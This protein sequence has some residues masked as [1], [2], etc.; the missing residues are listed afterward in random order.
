MPEFEKKTSCL[1]LSNLSCR[2][3]KSSSVVI[4]CS[5]DHGSFCSSRGSSKSCTGSFLSSNGHG[6]EGCCSSVLRGETKFSNCIWFPRGLFQRFVLVIGVP[7]SVYD[8]FYQFIW[9]RR[10]PFTK[11]YKQDFICLSSRWCITYST[12]NGSSSSSSS[13]TI[14]RSSIIDHISRSP[15]AGVVIPDVWGSMNDTFSIFFL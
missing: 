6:N 4:D 7:S 3:I 14:T 8:A 10:T 5:W 12:N 13:S 1:V 9:R 15:R 2:C 11:N